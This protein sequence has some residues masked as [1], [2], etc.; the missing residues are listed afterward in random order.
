MGGGLFQKLATHTHI[1]KKDF[2]KVD[3]VPR[4]YC[5]QTFHLDGRL[6][7]NLT[8]NDKTMTTPVYIK[9]DAH[10]QLLLSEGVCRQLGIITYHPS[11]EPWRGGRKS[12]EH[13]PTKPT[14]ENVN[15][16]R[17]TVRLISSLRIPPQKGVVVPVHVDKV[18]RDSSSVPLAF[19][20]DHTLYDSSKIHVQDYI[21]C[22][23]DDGIAYLLVE[24]TGGYTAV[25]DEGVGIGRVSPAELCEVKNE[26][27]REKAYV[28][29]IWTSE[30]REDRKKKLMEF[31]GIR[32]LREQGRVVEHDFQIS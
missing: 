18:T 16:P 30:E 1:R 6:D 11:A 29:T 28:N 15:V 12:A 9:F 24:N 4:I 23:D 17:I 2:K 13:Q 26:R 5:Q 21:I 25:L 20:A 27:Q 7:L 19:E 32:C 3:K 31:G 10:D 14:E 8:F 22:S